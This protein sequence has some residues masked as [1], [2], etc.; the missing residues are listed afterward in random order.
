MASVRD[1][2]ERVY[3]DTPSPLKVLSQE[4]V[5]LSLGHEV[6]FIIVIFDLKYSMN[7]CC[8]TKGRRMYAC[9]GEISSPFS[10]IRLFR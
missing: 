2:P 10:Q 6:Q 8:A 7:I 1:A 9:F 5:P 4:R 3:W